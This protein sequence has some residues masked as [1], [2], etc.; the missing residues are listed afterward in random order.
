[1]SLDYASP[2]V[3]AALFP[4]F[5]GKTVRLTCKRISVQGDTAVVQ[6]SDGGELR[7]QMTRDQHI[8]DAGPYVELIGNVLDP[9]TLKLRTCINL[10][11]EIDMSI[12]DG[13][14]RLTHDPRFINKFWVP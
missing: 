6:T 2:R 10:G 14:I 5:V 11:Q 7:V 3:N 9:T 8:G 4:Q 1:M 12:V 13:A